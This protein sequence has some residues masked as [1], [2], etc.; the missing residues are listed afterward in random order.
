MHES[1]V[2]REWTPTSGRPLTSL[3]TEIFFDIPLKL[4]TAG[5]IPPEL[6]KLAAL[7]K[8]SLRGNQ[9]SGETTV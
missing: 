9:L 4:S 8:L 7:K 3:K 2:D 5:P 6:G 1:L